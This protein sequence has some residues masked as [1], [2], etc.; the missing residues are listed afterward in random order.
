MLDP[1][2]RIALAVV[3]GI[4]MIIRSGGTPQRPWQARANRAAAGAMFAVAGYNAAE[5]AG[6]PLVATVA[7]ALGAIAFVTALALLVWSW[8]SGERRDVGDDVERMA[9]AYRERPRPRE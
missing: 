6:Q 2:L 1:T 5:L 4:I 9:R 7:A 3:L 8:R